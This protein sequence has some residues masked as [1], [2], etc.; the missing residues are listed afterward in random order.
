MTRIASLSLS[1]LGSL[2]VVGC[3]DR[4]DT[5]A[6]LAEAAADSSG[7]SQ[8]EASLLAS[9]FDGAPAGVAPATP[10][11]VAT[12][13]A[14]H[15]AARYSPAGCA[16]VTQAGLTVTVELAGCTGPRG[17]RELDGTLTLTAS[18]AAG[19]AVEVAAHA[20]A[21][22]LGQA[23]LDVDATAIYR[24]AGGTSSLDV[25]THSAGVGP[26]GFDLAHDGAYTVTWDASCVSIDGAWSSQR[27][28]ASRST[29]ADVTRC[30]DAC[31]QGSVTRVTARGVTVALTFDG[32]ATAQ[33][34][35]SAGGTGSFALACGL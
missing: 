33:W 35:S 23:T 16:T 4:A 10:D 18:P 26:R 3:A 34:T 15:A 30:L 2:L 12:Y 21:L 13:L 24:S 31:P 22:G 8:A 9:L 25:T 11:N 7:A 5:D 28:D 20:T 27:G 17:L 1:L 32:T 6:A 14:T 19:G 29:T